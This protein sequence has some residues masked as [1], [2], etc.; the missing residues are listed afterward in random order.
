MNSGNGRQTAK[1]QTEI[2]RQMGSDATRRY[3]AAQPL[4][5]P[6]E[7][8]PDYMRNLLDQLESAEQQPARKGAGTRS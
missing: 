2:S 4:F 3:L 5:R 1:L 8:M 7:A 6:V